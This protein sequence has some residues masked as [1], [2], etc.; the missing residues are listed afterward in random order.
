MKLRIGFA[1]ILSLFIVIGATHFY[2][3]TNLDDSLRQVVE[4]E[5]PMKES[6][7]EMEIVLG[8]IA[9]ALNDY[10]KTN[11][12]NIKISISRL[13]E[14][15]NTHFKVFMDLTAPGT[16]KKVCNELNTLFAELRHLG[17][18]LIMISETEVAD[19]AKLQQYIAEI[20][21]LVDEDLQLAK[22]KPG[23]EHSAKVESGL[24]MK[25]S[26]LQTMSSI[27][28]YMDTHDN[29]DLSHIAGYEA[30]F[31]EYF[32]QFKN[33]QLTNK[34]N[35]TV[36]I[37]QRDFFEVKEMGSNLIFQEDMKSS[38]LNNFE[39]NL[40]VMDSLLGH[41]VQ[42]E[43]NYQIALTAENARGTVSLAL[44]LLV[45]MLAAVFTIVWYLSN[46]FNTIITKP[47]I[48]ITKVAKRI[49][50]GETN[51]NINV[52]TDDEIGELATSLLT[53]ADSSQTLA[54]AAYDIGQGDFNP[55][56]QPRS[57]E[58][59][60]GKSLLTMKI[61]LKY[62]SIQNEEEEWLHNG[63]IELNNT[64][65]G[66][67]PA[68]QLAKELA[69]QI[70][71]Y[72]DAQIGAFYLNTEHNV[73]KLEGSYAID[74]ET[75]YKK[76][77]ELGEGL[78]G[79]AASEGALIVYRD[80]PKDYMK[81]N[82][83]LGETSPKTIIA[84]PYFYENKLTGL[85][86][87]GMSSDI[88]ELQ[89][90]FIESTTEIIG[91]SIFVAN[92][93][94]RLS[95]LLVETQA[96]SKELVIQAEELMRSEDELRR[97]NEELEE[98]TQTLAKSEEKLKTQ[99]EELRQ[100]NQELEEKANML[101]EQ[102]EMIT[103]AKFEIEEKVKELEL[104]SK[105]KSEF[106]ANMSHELR[107]PLN[108]ILILA[109]ILGENK[110]NNLTQK[111]VEFSKNIRSSGNDLL[112]L[113]DEILD[114]SKVES[115]KMETNPQYFKLNEV[116]TIMGIN[117]HELAKNRELTFEIT[118]PDKNP[119][120]FTDKLRLEQILKNL[121]SNAFK[122]TYAP[123]QIKLDIAI[124]DTN[125]R[126]GNRNL[127]AKKDN[128]AF[129][130]TD[131]GIGIALD[132]QQHVFDAFQQAEGS[133]KRRFG[134]TGLGLSISRELANLLGGEIHLETEEGKGSKFTL[135]LPSNSEG[136]SQES[137]KQLN[138]E[139]IPTAE[140]NNTAQTS[141]AES[142]DKVKDDRNN[143]KPTDKVVLII[144]DDLS[145]VNIL[146]DFIHER[147]YKGIVAL[148]GNM[149]LNYAR[150]YKPDA[151]ILD[152]K[153]P[154]MDGMKVMSYIK[155]D[156]SIR[157]I[158]V[159]ML[160]A[161]DV[162]KE[163][164]N[165]GAFDFIRKPTDRDD[166]IAAF[167]KM[168]AFVSRKLK[169][170][171]IIEDNKTQ[172]DLVKELLD[173]GDIKCIQAY[174]GKEGILHLEEGTTD[175]VILDLGLPDMKGIDLLE[176]TRK[177]KKL[178]DIPIIVYTGAELTKKELIGIEKYANTIVLKTA[179][180][181]ERLLA[182][183][184]LFLHRVERNLPKEKQ[185]T[186]RSLYNSDT[187]LIDKK[188]L[189]VDDEK[190]NLFSL[191]NLLVSEKMQ[192]I[193]AENGIEALKAIDKNLDIDI[194]LMDIM[195]PKMDGYEATRKIRKQKQFADLPIIALTAKIMEGDKEKCLEA[196]ASDYIS[197]PFDVQQLF[198]LMRVWLYN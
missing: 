60:L 152:C 119:Q 156:P 153:L 58:D 179:R 16:E 196:G 65:R 75:H 157:H 159:H 11:D 12:K 105:Y 154:V 70:T 116:S 149:G 177:N 71:T 83:S 123:G 9:N 124:A 94:K 85:L 78:A 39:R 151:I 144:E 187:V 87:I 188:V 146:L 15:F 117:F 79:Q 56:I 27:K 35:S 62:F 47:I 14:D 197:R 139:L 74:Q 125:I 138:S 135:Y 148:Q 145:F 4:I 100:A 8:D 137:S 118:Q 57:D 136:F 109:Q 18:E 121:L 59:I 32:Q 168:E 33:T 76:S 61:N 166:L 42:N 26:I 28:S 140:F 158:P 21:Q 183:T 50:L 142:L 195:M 63:I 165:G 104:T 1:I 31:A 88:T 97:S 175:C 92:S 80:V 68:I 112:S 99:Q 34:E 127:Y 22:A 181:N 73:L 101:E 141:V 38:L 20:D 17:S 182:E 155:N 102:K 185:T 48:Y 180:S 129:T 178:A 108:S 164:L 43:I 134:G 176:K 107:T 191:N 115:G 126:F 30:Q 45:F 167:D 25:I 122:F 110:S 54:R 67:K 106:L 169:E 53:I 7:L 36:D 2:G 91:T 161:F 163:S 46:Y 23:R 51:V 194:V 24:K 114:L 103:D 86:E 19:M 132:K 184:N 160:S 72:L 120:I 186:I 172:N 90:E 98:Q 37:I 150:T 5:E 81:I 192:V 84:C 82:S 193:T 171:L 69:T 55:I 77:I 66:D 174:S 130:V 162:K 52:K 13:E 147:K 41:T 49:A 131:T 170:V 111:Q 29:A 113:I 40:V 93:K 173:E 96:S 95:E 10:L 44:F 198:S 89:K 64:I 189:L 143:I 6:A 128:V 190:S 3:V 133:T